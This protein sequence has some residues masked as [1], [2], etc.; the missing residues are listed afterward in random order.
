MNPLLGDLDAAQKRLIELL[1]ITFRT[2]GAWPPWQ[3]VEQTI[4]NEG[5]DPVDVIAGFAPRYRAQSRHLRT[6]LRTCL[7]PRQF[8]FALPTE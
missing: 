3:F 4:M 7:N 6:H 1:A 8:R 5:L 2:Y